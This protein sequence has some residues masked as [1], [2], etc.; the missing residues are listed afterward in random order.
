[1]ENSLNIQSFRVDTKSDDYRGAERAMLERFQDWSVPED[2][3]LENLQLFITPQHLRRLLFLYEIYK[4]I[5]TVPGVI[6][7][8]GVRWGREL[9][10]F[11]SLRT[12]FEP[13][14]HSRRIIGFDTFSGYEGIADADGG[15]AMIRD[16][17]LA[18]TPGY[19]A[20]LETL[21]RTRESLSPL[22]H[23]Q[24]F[25]LVKG[26][27]EATLAEY[28]EANPHTIVS[29]AHLDMNLY[30]PT[31]RCLELL[32]EHVTKGSVIIIDEVNLDTFPGETLALK[33]VFGL[34][35]I[36][37]QRH[38]LVNPTWPAYFVVS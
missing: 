9:A 29:L 18:T 32:K 21:L 19:E 22:P 13:F 16:G 36:R 31:R 33:E 11:E 7:Q 5:L 25:T 35:S 6:M 30:R 12:T 28:L 23:V 15:N 20:E 34:S 1:M 3:K 38:P 27:A 4:E 24:K 8:F 2:E 10:L 17:N 14:N 26:N 37:L